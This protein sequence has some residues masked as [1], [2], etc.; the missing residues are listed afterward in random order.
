MTVKRKRICVVPS[1]GKVLDPDEFGICDDC[2]IVAMGV[3]TPWF[4]RTE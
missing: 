3:D 4:G 1:C 2:D